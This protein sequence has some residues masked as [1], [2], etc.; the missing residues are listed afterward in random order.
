M[1]AT[2]TALGRQMCRV[3]RWLLSWR[4][5]GALSKVMGPVL[6]WADGRVLIGKTDNCIRMSVA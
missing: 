2:D 5:E 4:I 1:L 3:A 6:R